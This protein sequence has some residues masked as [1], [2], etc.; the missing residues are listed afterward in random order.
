MCHIPFTSQSTNATGVRGR[1]ASLCEP[2]RTEGRLKMAS[3]R[4]WASQLGRAPMRISPYARAA[5][6]GPRWSILN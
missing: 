4:R 2:S 3:C 5:L 1:E 6:E